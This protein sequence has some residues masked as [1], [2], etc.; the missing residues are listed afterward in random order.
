MHHDASAHVRYNQPCRQEHVHTRQII[1]CELPAMICHSRSLVA[2]CDGRPIEPGN[3][4]PGSSTTTKRLGSTTKAR[5]ARV[6]SSPSSLSRPYQDRRRQPR[7]PASIP[8]SNPSL[9][10]QA[11]K[12]SGPIW[13]LQHRTDYRVLAG[14]R[15]GTIVIRASSFKSTQ[16]TETTRRQSWVAQRKSPDVSG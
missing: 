8:R 1:S 10:S 2:S 14:H 13:R 12:P 5:R 15:A 6:L 7:F 3:A 16:T 4:S 11:W 9:H